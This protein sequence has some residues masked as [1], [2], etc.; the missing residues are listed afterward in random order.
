MRKHILPRFKSLL[1]AACA[2]LYTRQVKPA[3]SDLKYEPTVPDLGPDDEAWLFDSD[4]AYE[5]KRV[6]LSNDMNALADDLSDLREALALIHGET[7]FPVEATTLKPCAVVHHDDVLF[8]GEV[9]APFIPAQ[10]EV[11]GGE[12]VY[13]FGDAPTFQDEAPAQQHAA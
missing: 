2:A 3:P 1:S 10:E 9:E 7:P 12:G 6:E 8:D 13:L 11:S 5:A 4:A